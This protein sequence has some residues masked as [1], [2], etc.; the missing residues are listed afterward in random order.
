VGG[1]DGQNEQCGK[2]RREWA[3]EAG[4]AEAAGEGGK[5]AGAR[6]GGAVRRMQGLGRAREASGGYELPRR[7]E[8]RVR[9][10]RGPRVAGE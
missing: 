8:E 6:G 10:L 4:R 2:G 1:E 9:G 3:N 7:W 5:G